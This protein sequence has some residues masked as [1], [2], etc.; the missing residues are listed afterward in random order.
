MALAAEAPSYPC[1]PPTTRSAFS[2]LASA[3]APSSW[4]PR[5]GIFATGHAVPQSDGFGYFS[6]PHVHGRRVLPEIL[7]K[8]VDAEIPPWNA[9][10]VFFDGLTDSG[11]S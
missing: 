7:L 6:L 1:R 5:S 3:S 8:M 9:N 10:W 2:A 11:T 4:D